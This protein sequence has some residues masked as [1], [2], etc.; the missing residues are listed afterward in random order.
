MTPDELRREAVELLEDA[1]RKPPK[2]LKAEVDV[3][4]QAVARLRDA[5][6]ERLRAGDASV[7]PALDSTNVALSLIVGV[8]YPAGGI[9]RQLLEQAQQALQQS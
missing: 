6:I 4:E 1:L 5:L 8:E 3:A 9:Q 7:R 2:E